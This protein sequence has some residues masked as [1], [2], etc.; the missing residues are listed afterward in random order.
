MTLRHRLNAVEAAVIRS[1]TDAQLEAIIGNADLSG[2]SDA[3]L[4]AIASGTA[5]AEL[6]QRFA[7]ATT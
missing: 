1:M 4:E 6:M 2:F 3:E 7:Y 5:P